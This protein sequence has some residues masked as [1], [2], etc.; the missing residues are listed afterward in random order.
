MM[1][2]KMGRTEWQRVLGFGQGELRHAYPACLIDDIIL[3]LRLVNEHRED[4]VVRIFAMRCRGIIRVATAAFVV[5]FSA[6][7]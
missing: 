7:G 3:Y 6:H 1:I 4:G 2:I 5:S